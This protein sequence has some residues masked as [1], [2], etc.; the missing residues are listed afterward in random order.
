ML[1]NAFKYVTHSFIQSSSS[2]PTCGMQH[3]GKRPPSGSICCRSS[4]CL[5]LQPLNTLEFHNVSAAPFSYTE[6]ST[7]GMFCKLSWA[8]Y[9][10]FPTRMVYLCYISCLRYTIL[11]RNPRY[12][13]VLQPLPILQLRTTHQSVR[14]S[15]G[16]VG[17]GAQVPGVKMT[18]QITQGVVPCLQLLL[19]GLA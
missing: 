17:V 15:L 1:F 6:Q 4:C 18:T 3:L 5:K 16:R 8:I 14:V 19:Q 9:Q 11:V 7:A 10:G 12:R 13:K 2:V